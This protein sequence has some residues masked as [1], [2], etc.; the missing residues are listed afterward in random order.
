MKQHIVLCHA[1]DIDGPAHWV[2]YMTPDAARR[3]A[4]A[5]AKDWPYVSVRPIG[6]AFFG[7]RDGVEHD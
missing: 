7:V 5:L 1:N 4:K 2:I 6:D 3:A